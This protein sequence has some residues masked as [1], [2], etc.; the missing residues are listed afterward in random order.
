MARPP[1]DENGN[2]LR[3]VSS[4]SSLGGAGVGVGVGVSSESSLRT[5][6]SADRGLSKLKS[7]SSG[8]LTR[9]KGFNSLKGL[10]QTHLKSFPNGSVERCQSQIEL[11]PAL[12]PPPPPA[13]PQV[14]PAW[15]PQEEIILFHS[16][17]HHKPVGF[18]RHLHMIFIQKRFESRWRTREPAERVPER[19][20]AEML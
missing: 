7:S 20:T 8:T 17:I 15:S 11:S 9:P 14:C 5:S 10:S 16:L 13:P 4:E 19:V 3:G 18:D 12:P 1:G 2:Y 6:H